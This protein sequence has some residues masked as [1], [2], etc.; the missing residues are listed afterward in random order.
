[1]I[2]L[3]LVDDQKLFVKSL[4]RVIESLAEE[5]TVIGIASD[6]K[7]ALRQME[8]VL[9]DILLLD[10]RMPGMDGVKTAR[11]VAEKYPD[12]QVVM[13]TTFD[14]DDYIKE[15]LRYGA[16][17]YILKDI[18]PP[19]LIASIRAIASGSVLISPSV[20]SKL[21]NQIQNFEDKERSD[22]ET[23]V[24]SIPPWM[25]SLSPRER[26][27]LKLIARGLTNRQ[28]AESLFIAEQTV[29]NHVSVI[30]S[31]LGVHNRITTMQMV[32]E[33]RINK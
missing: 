7:E 12:V 32:M 8:S 22:E 2:R 14:N 6:G 15:A 5:M 3:M 31:K 26:E 33:A 4:K 13:L 11:I 30:Y 28:I 24:D 20:A 21:F 23:S 16:V 19:D 1:M 18:E 9:P 17:G 27:V 25:K 10:V 29:R